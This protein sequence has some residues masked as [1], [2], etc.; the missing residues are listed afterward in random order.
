MTSA[1]A[2]HDADRERE[3]YLSNTD[4]CAA[5]Q[6]TA[7][8]ESRLLNL[9]E[10]EDTLVCFNVKTTEHLAAVVV[11]VAPVLL[12]GAR[13][14]SYEVIV[15]YQLCCDA[16][17]ASQI[18]DQIQDVYDAYVQAVRLRL[19]EKWYGRLSTSQIKLTY[20]AMRNYLHYQALISRVVRIQE[21][22]LPGWSL[23]SGFLYGAPNQTTG[24]GHIQA[25]KETRHW[26]TTFN[27]CLAES[28]PSQ[29]ALVPAAM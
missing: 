24:L 29:R 25:K 21:H 26:G 1:N 4:V 23:K 15:Y 5:S 28:R 19:H 6:L 10:A 20:A 18:T 22:D 3:I 2:L 27:L 8:A 11:K 16:L 9:S 7:K 12:P 17:Q 14:H 13:H